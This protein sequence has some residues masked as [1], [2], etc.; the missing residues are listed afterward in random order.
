MHVPA[1]RTSDAG[2]EAASQAA[3]AA[4]GSASLLSGLT[5]PSGG[6]TL[7]PDSFAEL[8]PFHLVLDS[9]LNI[10]QVCAFFRL[11]SSPPVPCSRGPLLRQ[12]RRSG[13][14]LWASCWALRPADLPP[15]SVELMGLAVACRRAF[16][17][18]STAPC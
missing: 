1:A 5:G 6:F 3:G 8:F 4:A 9:K 14:D 16:P 2:N 13:P 11:P 7:A 15:W 12:R 18:R 17:L 10:M